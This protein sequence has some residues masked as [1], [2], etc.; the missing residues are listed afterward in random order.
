MENWECGTCVEEICVT[1]DR[2]R[3]KPL[4]APPKPSPAPH[5][6]FATKG[7]IRKNE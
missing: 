6:V 5:N 1:I 7:E 2:V 3:P 4:S